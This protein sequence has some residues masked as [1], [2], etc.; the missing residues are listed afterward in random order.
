MAAP[1]APDPAPL[2]RREGYGL[3]QR[4]QI[5]VGEE[6]EAFTPGPFMLGRRGAPEDPAG[7]GSAQGLGGRERGQPV[8]T[9]C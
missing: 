5:A 2:P 4:V 3:G 6:N 8:L 9:C 7:R 1:L